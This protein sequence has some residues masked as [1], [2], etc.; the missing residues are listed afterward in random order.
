MLTD[1]DLYLL[2]HLSRNTIRNLHAQGITTIAQFAELSI[3]EMQQVKGIKKT[4]FALR[5]NALAYVQN[6]PVWYGVLP[7][8]VQRGGWMLDLETLALINRGGDVW[9]IGWADLAGNVQIA[10][11]GGYCGTLTPAPDL[12]IHIVPD[13]DAAWFAVLESMQGDDLP[14]FHWTGFDAG[15]IA[16]TAP[17][18]VREALLDRMHD[19]YHS[20]ITTV[21][22]PQ[23]SY[24]I[25][26][27]ARY[28][29][30]DWEVYARWDAAERDYHQWEIDG[31]RYLLYRACAYQRDDVLAL[32]RVWDW[33]MRHA[34]GCG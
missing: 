21:R 14:I 13:S 29:G 17:Q 7:E 18:P 19:L 3:E 25:K 11:V 8:T 10:V 23:R 6:A 32:V 20:F 31:D 4:A 12:T 9:C 2:P 30:F 22:L 26:E 16:S 28:I 33:L 15:I 34:P 24:S 5:A 1:S 27:V